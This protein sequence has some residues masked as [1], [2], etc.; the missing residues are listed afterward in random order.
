MLASA[1]LS[2]L[3]AFLMSVSTVIESAGRMTPNESTLKTDDGW[4]T[5][6]A[7]AASWCHGRRRTKD[8]AQTGQPYRLSIGVGFWH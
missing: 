4:V 3:S 1:R 5:L 6:F 2:C 8:D 7:E